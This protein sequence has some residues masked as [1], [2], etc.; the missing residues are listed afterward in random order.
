M[1][2]TSCIDGVPGFGRS[3]HARCSDSPFAPKYIGILKKAKRDFNA[4]FGDD[5][6]EWTYQHDGA[7]PHKAKATNTWLGENVPNFIPSGPAGDWPP[8]SPD[9]NIIEQVWGAMKDKLQERRSPSLDA[10]KRRIRSL[11][12]V[13]T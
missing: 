12:D 11:W 3:C 10:L 6:D 2:D 7:S 4:I 9:L 8:N 5:N 1:L 13:D